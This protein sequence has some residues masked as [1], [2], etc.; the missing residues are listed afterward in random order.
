MDNRLLEL[1]KKLPA[2]EQRRH[3][4]AS[5]DKV[6]LRRSKV[7]LHGWAL[8]PTL[9]AVA[10]FK[11]VLGGRE[12]DNVVLTRS[13]R[14]DVSLHFTGAEI[15]CGFSLAFSLLDIPIDVDVDSKLSVN[16]TDFDLSVWTEKSVVLPQE[17]QSKL[18]SLR[19][20]EMPSMPSAAREVLRSE[21]DGS[22]CY[23]EYGTGGSTLMACDIGVP[24]IFG[25]ESDWIWLW[26][27]KKAVHQR[28]C[29]ANTV[30]LMHC[31]IGPSHEWGFASDES[32]W[33]RWSDYPLK[34]WSEIR[35]SGAEPD[36]VLID[37]RFRVA[38]FFAT[39]IFANKGCKIL[40][41]DYYDRPYYEE[42]EKFLKP[43]RT[44]DRMAVFEVPER[45]D[46]SSLWAAM[47][48]YLSDQ[49]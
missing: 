40:W 17:I 48:P 49:R 5:I 12:I 42:I 35:R 37:G 41:D 19:I 10:N 45:S 44:A 39:L 27:V 9:S 3:A 15:D 21:L 14:P 36:T 18:A 26:A 8:S 32:N 13:A 47:I 7:L 28:K 25:V 24:R 22:S 23:V 31:D 2:F 29:A 1:D 38:C 4:R 34:I 11:V 6:E 30:T 16:L 33:K 46:V 43:S 20:P